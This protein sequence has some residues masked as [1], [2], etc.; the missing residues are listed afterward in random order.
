LVEQS[1]CDVRFE[2]DSIELAREAPNHRAKKSAGW[3]GGL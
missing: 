3:F 2:E 1:Q